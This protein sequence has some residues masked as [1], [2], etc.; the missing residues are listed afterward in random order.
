[1]KRLSNPCAIRVFSYK[2]KQPHLSYISS[3]R[4]TKTYNRPSAESSPSPIRAKTSARALSTTTNLASLKS[5]NPAL[6]SENKT[7]PP[8]AIMPLQIRAIEESDSETWISLW[9]QYNQFYKRTIPTEVTQTTLTRFLDPTVRMYC[10]LAIDP[11]SSK[12]IGFVTWYPH[13]TTSSIQEIVYLQD[14]FVDSSVRNKGTGRALIEHVY[15]HAK[16]IPVSSVYW[17]TQYFNYVGQILYNKVAT[18]TDF[19]RYQKNF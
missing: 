8:A 18:R 3:S 16:T 2:N 9:E 7:Q 14:L 19:I 17:N 11:D 4:F 15:E 13:P 5:T 1:M 12:T 10:A 6:S